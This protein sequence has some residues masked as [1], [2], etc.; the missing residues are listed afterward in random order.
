[1]AGELS[2]TLGRDPKFWTEPTTFDPTRFTKERAEDKKHKAIFLPFGAGAHAC[3]G[4]QLAGLEIKAFWHAF[5]SR[6]RFRLAKDYR[7][8]HSYAPIGTVTGDIDLVLEE[9]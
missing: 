2:G 7:A 6:C 4:A 1:M 5:L 8:R 9:V 3:I